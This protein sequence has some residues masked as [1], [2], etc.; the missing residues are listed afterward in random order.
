MNNESFAPI[1]PDD[2]G[3]VEFEKT[4]EATEELHLADVN[5]QRGR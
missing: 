1:W 4:A 3:V 2:R 5:P